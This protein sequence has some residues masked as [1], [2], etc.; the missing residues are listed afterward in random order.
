MSLGEPDGG[1]AGE[2][3]VVEGKVDDQRHDRISRCSLDETDE[4]GFFAPVFCHRPIL[5]LD[6]K[7]V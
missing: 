3:V 1:K 6:P 7:M 5:Q 4:A 2:P